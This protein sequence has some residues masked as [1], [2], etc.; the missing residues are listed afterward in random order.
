MAAVVIQRNRIDVAAH[1]RGNHRSTM[2]I[3][4]VT[5]RQPMPR[6]SPTNGRSQN[7][8]VVI[9]G[10]FYLFMNLWNNI[11]LFTEQDDR[12]AASTIMLALCRMRYWAIMP[13]SIDD[14]WIEWA[15]IVFNAY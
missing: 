14:Q 1:Q 10:M 9:Q 7:E 13:A 12:K 2:D 5:E 6:I 11:N 15:D 8:I 3:S 4:T